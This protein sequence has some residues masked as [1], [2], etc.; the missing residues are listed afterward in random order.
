[1]EIFSELKKPRDRLIEMT[2][3]ATAYGVFGELDKAIDTL[4]EA[5]DYATNVGDHLQR[6]LVADNLADFLRKRENE[7]DK[8]EI[9]RCFNIDETF[10]RSSGHTRDLI[11]SIRNQLVYLY[12]KE[13]VEV[14]ES[15]LW[16]MKELVSKY[17]FTEFDQSVRFFEWHASNRKKQNST[18]SLDQA[19]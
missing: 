6:A 16:E 13:P 9:L 8:E 11:I 3:L 5:L 15:K 10:F 19:K 17:G 7:A 18:I 12:D 4:R 1:M 14:W 2:N